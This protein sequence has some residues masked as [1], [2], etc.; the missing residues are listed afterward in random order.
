MSGTS[1]IQ[2]NARARIGIVLKDKWQLDG[3]LG[4]GG[5]AAVYS[6]THRN[7]KRA[8]IKMLHAELASNEG[9]VVRFLGEG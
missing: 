3:L 8:A 4:V 9:L 7:G 5:T 6:A 2:A 1:S